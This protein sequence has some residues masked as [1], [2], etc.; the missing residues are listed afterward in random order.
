MAER[1]PTPENIPRSNEQI[2]TSLTLDEAITSLAALAIKKGLESPPESILQ[3]HLFEE[4]MVEEEANSQYN[5]APIRQHFER[6]SIK[7]RNSYIGIEH[8]RLLAKAAQ[9]RSTEATAIFK[10]LAFPSAII[11][12]TPEE[13]M[14]Q[15]K[16]L[17]KLFSPVATFTLSQFKKTELYR[18]KTR[19]EPIDLSAIGINVARR[20]DL[21]YP[22]IPH[23]LLDNVFQGRLNNQEKI[24]ETLIQVGGL[25]DI[26]NNIGNVQLSGMTEGKFNNLTK[27]SKYLEDLVNKIP[28]SD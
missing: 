26:P 25:I 21:D 10:V 2:S 16:N 6:T 17:S 1:L 11:T 8:F 19:V 3:T 20:S 7:S 4:D 23:E 24:Q 5:R 9:V 13:H 18:I 12:I 28:E 27:I 14:A 22:I 15:Y